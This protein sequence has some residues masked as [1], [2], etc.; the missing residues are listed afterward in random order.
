MTLNYILDE[1]FV[2]NSTVRD[3][4]F[5]QKA[6]KTVSVGAEHN[7]FSNVLNRDFYSEKPMQ[8]L[9]TDVT[10]IKN[11]DKWYYLACY[12]DLFNNEIVDCGTREPRMISQNTHNG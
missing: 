11:K 6:K 4:R 8:K 5:C 9:V 10:Y 12:L 3:Y 1:T 2:K 7:R